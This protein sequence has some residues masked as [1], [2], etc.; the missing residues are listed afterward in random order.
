MERKTAALLTLGCRLN[1]ADSALL[2]NRLEKMG[3][4][5]VTPDAAQSPNLIIVNSCAVTANAF[6]KTR[7]A[8]RAVR[9]ENPQSYLV[10]TGCA[11]DVE[12]QK[13]EASPECDLVL[14]NESKQKLES[15]LARRLAYLTP[16]EKENDAAAADLPEGVYREGALSIF[17]FKSRG[18]LKIQDGCNCFCSYCVV[19]YAR[20]RERSR[21]IHE[22]LADFQQFLQAGF[23]EIVLSGVNLCSYHC[24][25]LDLAGLLKLL[26]S[27]EGDFRIRIGSVEPGKELLKVI[28]VMAEYPE[29]ICPFL[30]IPLQSGC[31]DILKLMKRRYLTTEYKAIVSAARKKISHLHLG[32]DLIVGFPG[33]TDEMFE[34]TYQFVKSLK[35]A[36]IHIF[37]FSP[38]QGTPA[39]E[40]EQTVSPC[41][42]EERILRM[43]ELKETCEHAF[44]QSLVG[45]DSSVLVETKRASGI[46]E[47]WSANYA[48]SRIK[49][50]L[51]LQKRLVDVTFTG[52]LDGNVMETKLIHPDPIGD[53]DSN[54]GE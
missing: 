31:D 37:P 36:N 51:R 50:K 12:K 48:K 11:A 34:T 5:M 43:K 14:T 46:Y 52:V 47:G 10:L 9:A 1:Q 25:E 7:Q 23:H 54:Q 8:L 35:F 18:T 16:P 2:S 49:T 27:E 3:F 40:M 53:P 45:T 4:E 22:V 30:H 32:T 13:L 44:Y 17:P 33:E 42:M 26:A 41:T 15:I 24:G 19:P 29:K 6:K 38:R 21:D 28:D 39:A 20:G